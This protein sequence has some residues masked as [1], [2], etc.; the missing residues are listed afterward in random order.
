MQKTHE[1]EAQLILYCSRTA[2]SNDEIFLMR[3]LV[4]SGLDWEY[5]F[6]KSSLHA[7]LPLL[8]S[9]LKRY[10][11][12][13]LP[14]DITLQIKKTFFSSCT[15]SL[16]Q[17][18]ALMQIVD[19][20]KEQNIPS[21]SFKGPV[22]AMDLY[23]DIGLRSFGD[24]DIL[25]RH[26]DLQK[27]YT[28]LLSC[29]YCP[30]LHLDRSRLLAYS[31]H[32]DNLSFV[33][34]GSTIIIELHWDLSGAYLARPLTFEMLQSHLYEIHLSGKLIA[35][36]SSE[37]LLV[38]LCIHGSKHI[39]ER[40]EWI[41]GVAMLLFEKQNLDWEMVFNLAEDLQCERM[42]LVGLEL[43]H[44]ILK[45]DLPDIALQ[46]IKEDQR[47]ANLVDIASKEVELTSENTPVKKNNRFSF[48]HIY[49]RDSSIDSIR[50][51]LRLCFRPTNMEWQTIQLPVSLSSLYYFVRPMRLVCEY[52][53]LT[54]RAGCK[55]NNN[56]RNN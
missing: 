16:F 24:L 53:S 13:V 44:R 11:E 14:K 22:L 49:V 10:C 33:R 27:A 9:Q 52:F 26:C 31:C 43:A 48:F 17:T 3:S 2:L 21:L 6:Q 19:I 28:L 36:L 42:L 7:L 45:V 54:L 37:Q 32:E 4:E 20:F 1:N 55:E 38:Y 15:R 30:E 29:G 23:K 5:L 51:L 39:W 41:R 50:Y 34:E 56:R 18:G 12:E 40:L 25:I 8:C 46:K 35:N 47:V